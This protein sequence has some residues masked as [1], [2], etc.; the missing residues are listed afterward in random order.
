MANIE[1]EDE[2]EVPEEVELPKRKNIATLMV[3]N[4]SKISRKMKR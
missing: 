3:R 4:I 1:D 2:E